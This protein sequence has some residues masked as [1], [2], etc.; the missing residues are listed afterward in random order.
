VLLL[1]IIYWISDQLDLIVNTNSGSLLVLNRPVGVATAD[2]MA[3]TCI[4]TIRYVRA[5][6]QY[7]SSRLKAQCHELSTVSFFLS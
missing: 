3:R 5:E 4:V 7:D 1:L 6:L 2:E